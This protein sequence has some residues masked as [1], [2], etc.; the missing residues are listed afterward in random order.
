MDEIGKCSYLNIIKFNGAFHF[1]DK[2]SFFKKI[3][4]V[5]IFSQISGQK[6]RAQE[7][8]LVASG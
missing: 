7:E 4:K 5:G 3:V 8:K 6:N 1:S 2:S